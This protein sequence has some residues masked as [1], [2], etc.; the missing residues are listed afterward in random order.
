MVSR[1]RIGR[2]HLYR[3]TADKDGLRAVTRSW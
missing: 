2:A 3:A 1:E